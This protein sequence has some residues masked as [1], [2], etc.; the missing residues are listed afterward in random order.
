MKAALTGNGRGVPRRRVHKPGA[1]QL[2]SRAQHG[3]PLRLHDVGRAGEVHDFTN[4]WKVVNVRPSSPPTGSMIGGRIRRMPDTPRFLRGATA[5]DSP[6][7][8]L[9]KRFGE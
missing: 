7:L 3:L 5:V 1:A 4:R 9:A 6:S 2:Q 8:S